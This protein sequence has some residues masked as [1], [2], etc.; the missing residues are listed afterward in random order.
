MTLPSKVDLAQVVSGALKNGSGARR[1]AG[2]LA[3]EMIRLV[4]DQRADAG[5]RLRVKHLSR[6]W[7]ESLCKTGSD[8]QRTT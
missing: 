2:L 3:A 8:L 1:V 5:L 4:E 6:K 7:H